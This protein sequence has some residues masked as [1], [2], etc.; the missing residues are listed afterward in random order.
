VVDRLRGAQRIAIFTHAKPDGDAIGS[1][2]AL[3]R[4]LAAAGKAVVVVY[5]P[6]VP[7]RFGPMLEGVTVLRTEEGGL[8]DDR[9]RQSDLRVVVDTGSRAQLAD[10]AEFLAAAPD[11][12]IA[13]DHHRHGDPELSRDRLIEPEC[14]AA[15][16]LVA[17]ICTGVLG[18]ASPRDLP[19]DIASALYLGIATDTGWFRHPNTRSS[20]HR[21]AADLIDA[22]VDHDA[23]FQRV[24]QSDRPERLRLIARALGTLEFV[25]D[26]AA[27][28]LSITAADFA[29]TGTGPE[30]TGGIVDVPRTV[31][32][33]RVVALL[34]DVTADPAEPMTKISLRSKAG[35][36]LM[37]VNALAQTMNG[38]GHIH[39]AGARLAMPVAEARREVVRAL[40]DMIARADAGAR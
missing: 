33:V 17:P 9:V 39:A 35:E 2:T 31:E 4:A 16:E 20:S 11:A 26:G 6:P 5:A 14:P 27:A 25:A 13:I 24:E 30:D 37:D 32:A 3:A 29:E 23:L 36:P 38:G 21:I 15:C 1:S 8:D 10:A 22:G 7:E 19:G 40:N 28:V 34:Y 18:V 12:V